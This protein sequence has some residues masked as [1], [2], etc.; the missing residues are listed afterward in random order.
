MLAWKIFRRAVML[1]VDNLG[2]ALRVS[3]LPY[4][5]FTAA[6][7]VFVGTMGV[8]DAARLEAGGMATGTTLPA[9]TILAI[10]VTAIAQGLAFLWIA[11]AWH[12]YVLLAEGGAGWIPA[13]HGGRILGYLGRSIL[14]GLMVACIFL[15]VTVAI[16]VFSPPAAVALASILSLVVSYRLGMILPAG[17]I[18]KPVTIGEAWT[19]TRGQSATMVLLAILTFLLSLLFQVPALLDGGSLTPNDVAAG[20]AGA[21]PAGIVGVVY[22]LV[23][24]WILLLVGVSIL[25]TLYG[26]FIEGRALD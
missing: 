13:F 22:D 3:A 14:I 26:H 18:G 24:S 16:G 25:S 17:A 23:A 8:G 10:F 15:A 20:S 7:L 5:I 1:V 21:G 19:A 2:A 11:V 12:R 9:G 6:S 4:A